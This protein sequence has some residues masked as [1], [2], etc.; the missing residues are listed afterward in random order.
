M[1][2]VSEDRRCFEWL[3]KKC[4]DARVVKR[5]VVRAR[6]REIKGRENGVANRTPETSEFLPARFLRAAD[7]IVK[8]NE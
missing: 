2:N 8:K 4:G 7:K 6:Q 3:E 5:T 1:R